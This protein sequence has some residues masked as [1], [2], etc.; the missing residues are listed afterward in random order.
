MKKFVKFLVV[1][2]SLTLCVSALF[3]CTDT[4]EDAPEEIKKEHISGQS[5]P[6]QTALFNI[7]QSMTP[8]DKKD[9]YIPNAKISIDVKGYDADYTYFDCVL[10]ATW[11]YTEI[12][13]ENPTGAEKTISV[14]LN[15]NAN[16]D[17]S[18][19]ETV[20]LLGCRGISNIS[21][22]YEW[23]GTATKL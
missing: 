18:H 19:E 8:A 5:L 16:G 14:T 6:A 13:D 15:L 23:L 3:S 2:L 9:G 21:V 7:K 20:T 12:S 22:N 1:L 11:T 10:V 17:G 4:L